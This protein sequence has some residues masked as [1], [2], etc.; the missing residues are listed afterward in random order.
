MKIINVV[1]TLLCEQKN[2]EVVAQTREFSTF[3]RDLID[4]AG[5]LKDSAVELVAM[6]ST[7]IYL[8]QVYEAIEDVMLNASVVN[9]RH[10]KNGLYPN[11]SRSKHIPWARFSNQ[12]KIDELLF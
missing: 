3:R 6:E 2:G 12:E 10:V 1:C 8:K 5:W 7:G 9:A 4:L 11:L